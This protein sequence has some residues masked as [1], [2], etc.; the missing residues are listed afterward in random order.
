LT[1]RP[2]ATGLAGIYADPG[3]VI[4]DPRDGLAH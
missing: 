2:L 4:A 1:E 3:H